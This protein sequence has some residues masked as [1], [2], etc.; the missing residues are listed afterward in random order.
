MIILPFDFF[1][2]HISDTVGHE[3]YNFD[4][5]GIFTGDQKFSYAGLKGNAPK[6]ANFPPVYPYPG[7]FLYCT[8]I[9]QVFLSP[10]CFQ[11]KDR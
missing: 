6:D 7:A 11:V 4:F 9:Q 8:Q 2:I 1:N 10:L 5:N 3:I